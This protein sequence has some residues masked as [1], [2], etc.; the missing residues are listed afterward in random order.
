MVRSLGQPERINGLAR[1]HVHELVEDMGSI[2]H[3][4]A[5]VAQLAL[6]HS[7]PRRLRVDVLQVLEDAR[8]ALRVHL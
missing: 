7:C 1:L 6:T 2:V 5:A 4:H 8:C 3:M